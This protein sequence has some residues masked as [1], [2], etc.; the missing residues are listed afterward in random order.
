MNEI[1]TPPAS[2][3]L[4]PEDIGPHI[5]KMVEEVFGTM[6]NLKAEPA[7]STESP[8]AHERISGSIGLAGERVIGAIYLHLTDPLA[9]LATSAM[10][11]LPVEELG[12]GTE[13]NDV[14]GEMT[15]MMA[16]GFKSTL[17]DIGAV[18]AMSTP[19]IIRGQAFEIKVAPDVSQLT[20]PFTCQGHHF[21]IEIHL[22][23]TS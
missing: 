18:C 16:G 17:C 4:L 7:R 11:G 14:V 22:K 10:L 5:A 21:S 13:I 1:L 15:N 12:A 8:P 6:L 20:Y 9:R 3:V 19:A 2:P 23:I